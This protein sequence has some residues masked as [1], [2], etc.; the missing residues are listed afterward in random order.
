MG[1]GRF[2]DRISAGNSGEIE[3][4]IVAKKEEIPKEEN[5]GRDRDKLRGNIKE[6]RI[7]GDIEIREIGVQGV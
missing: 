3:F 1:V 2:Y 6:N 4:Q 7:V 5:E